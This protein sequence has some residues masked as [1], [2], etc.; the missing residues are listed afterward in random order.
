MK[1]TIQTADFE[2]VR[3]WMKFGSGDSII[4]GI[5]LPRIQMVENVAKHPKLKELVTKW[6][7]QIDEISD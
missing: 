6:K 7:A 1:L 3:Y 5:L 4:F 2:E